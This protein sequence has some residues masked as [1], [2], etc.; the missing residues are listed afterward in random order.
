[1]WRN[2][3]VALLLVALVM[4]SC[5]F[6]GSCGGSMSTPP[7][8]NGVPMNL[9]I[10][11]TPP[12]GVAVLF[13]EALITGASLQPSDMTKAAVP[14]VTTPV[15]V[16][17][18][19][20]QTDTAFLSLSNIPADTY[21]SLTLTFGNAVLTIVNHSGA[22]IGSCANNSVCQMMPTFNPST[23]TLASPFPI[24]V[25]A[26]QT[27]GIKLDFDVNA[28][29]Q[30]DLSVNPMVSV[31]NVTQRRREDDQ[32]DMEEADDVDG[33]VTALGTNMFTLMNE[34]S[35]Q[36]F[37]VN[38]DSNTVFEDFDKAGCTA[39]PQ[40]FSCVMM[41][42]IVEVDLSESGTGTMLA[43]RVK[44]EEQVNQEALKA[45]ITSVDSSGTQFQAVVFNEEPT[46]NGV[47]EGGT[48]VVTILPTTTF[49]ASSE[50]MGEDSGFTQT[51][52]SFASAADLMVGQDV[53]IHPQMVS[54]T[55]GVTTITAD[56]IRLR[57]SQITGQVGT[58]NTDGTF[59]L[60]PASSLFTM[61]TPAVASIK[62]IPVFEME[63][64]DVS[65]LSALATGN[66]VSVK[67]L[68]FNTSGTPTL[69]AKAIRKQ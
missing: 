47:S 29:L 11:D 31:V 1:M 24:T 15:E 53:Q 42:E 21:K 64:E 14:V 6:L 27:F 34:R 60:T 35:G 5:A 25:T 18:G 68:L 62:V 43:K 56:R 2:F 8:V 13:F 44:L 58:I 65:G 66:T 20:L 9:S 30:S 12:S 61:A 50:E 7:T 37:T 46:V 39:S 28:S 48:V 3:L 19:H 51:G 16:E 32:G 22:A 17:F 57:P 69:L 41:G 55:G 38:V 4:V 54:S 45:T 26:D 40:N 63:F 49:G 36:S 59:T 23:A 33:Q 52:L 67:G 10:R